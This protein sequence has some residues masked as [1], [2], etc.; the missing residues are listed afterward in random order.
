MPLTR[1]RNE[2]GSSR[3]SQPRTVLVSLLAYAGL[4]PGEALAL[5]WRHIGERTINVEQSVSFGEMKNTK[6]NSSRT[7][8]LL[9]PLAFQCAAFQKCPCAGG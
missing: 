2:R 8:R 6:T 9:V 1:L 3:S 5:R 7:V 4:R